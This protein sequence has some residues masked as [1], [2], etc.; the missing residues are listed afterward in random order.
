MYL[1]EKTLL[2]YEKEIIGLRQEHLQTCYKYE[3]HIKE[4]K[5]IISEIKN[6]YYKYPD[7]EDGPSTTFYDDE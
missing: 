7:A 5:Q 2:D 3:E 6:T 1:I 4:L